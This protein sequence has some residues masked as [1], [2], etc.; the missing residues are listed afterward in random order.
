MSGRNIILLGNGDVG[1]AEMEFLYLIVGLEKKEWNKEKGQ[2]KRQ[3]S[4]D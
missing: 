3:V 4:L 1:S 2:I